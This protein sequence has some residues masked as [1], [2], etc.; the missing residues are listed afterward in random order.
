MCRKQK[1]RQNVK[2]I[3]W[4][5]DT[6]MLK[7]AGCWEFPVSSD[8]QWFWLYYVFQCSTSVVSAHS[9]S[10]CSTA[11]IY[12]PARS[13]VWKIKQRVVLLSS[14]NWKQNQDNQSNQREGEL[15]PYF[16]IL[17]FSCTGCISTDLWLNQWT[18]W[19]RIKTVAPNILNTIEQE[20][21]KKKSVWGNEQVYCQSILWNT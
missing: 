16:L 13:S 19:A 10:V 12:T 20:K 1:N 3:L 21:E 17:Y 4:G 18:Q 6:R 7:T 8:A 9:F 11:R 15:S 5:L 2:I 14:T